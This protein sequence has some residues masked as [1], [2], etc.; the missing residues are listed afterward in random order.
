MT[1]QGAIIK[2]KGVTFGIV[3]VKPQVLDDPSRRD[4]L[5]AQ[6]AGVFGGIPTILMGQRG[7]RARYYG[8]PDIV[9]FM[10]KVPISAVPWKQYRFRNAA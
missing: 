3:V 10:A 1:F 8:R 5:V 2:E 7:T 9:R 6:C 4:K